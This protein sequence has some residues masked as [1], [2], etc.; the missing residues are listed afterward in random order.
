MRGAFFGKE[1]VVKFY[2][3]TARKHDLFYAG[4]ATVSK[5]ETVIG[6]TSYSP[7]VRNF[8]TAVADQFRDVTKLIRSGNTTT[9]KTWI[10]A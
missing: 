2:L 1:S 5:K 4:T 9:S 10:T 6:Y 8:R 7:V 3:T